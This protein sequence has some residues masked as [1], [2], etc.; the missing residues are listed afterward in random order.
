MNFAKKLSQLI[1]QVFAH[2]ISIFTTAQNSS[3]FRTAIEHGQ[4]ATS[5]VRVFSVKSTKTE[6]GH[7]FN[8]S[9]NPGLA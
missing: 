9:T 1:L 2:V 4:I 5:G 7:Q 6:L 8:A 3:L